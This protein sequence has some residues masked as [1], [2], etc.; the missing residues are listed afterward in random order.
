M[1]ALDQKEAEHLIQ[2]QVRVWDLSPRVDKNLGDQSLR[3]I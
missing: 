1:Y 3:S 2:K